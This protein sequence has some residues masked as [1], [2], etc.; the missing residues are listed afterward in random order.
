M[1][2]RTVVGHPYSGVQ[3][4]FR[5]AK[6][7]RFC[8]VSKHCLPHH[9]SAKLSWSLLL[10]ERGP[11]SKS[12]SPSLGVPW[13]QHRPH[14][15]TAHHSSLTLC[16]SALLSLPCCSLTPPCI[17]PLPP[18]P[19][20]LLPWGWLGRRLGSG[21]RRRLL[22]TGATIAT[23]TAEATPAS[24]AARHLAGWSDRGLKSK[25]SS[26]SNSR[27]VNV[28]E[29][30]A[31]INLGVSA[32]SQGASEAQAFGSVSSGNVER[33]AAMAARDARAAGLSGS[34]GSAQQ[35]AA[36]AGPQPRAASPCQ[37]LPNLA[38]SSRELRVP[39]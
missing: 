15:P 18:H 4:Y 39:R 20:G 31:S 33:V 14:L 11:A 22:A 26:N 13:Q 10:C 32:T 25:G 34:A 6:L 38:P 16:R 19:A 2:A 21:L 36:G 37:P 8:R 29:L 3:P 23:S 12:R 5:L 7:P 1:R 35:G 28:D 9:T 24:A 30:N 17:L 27:N